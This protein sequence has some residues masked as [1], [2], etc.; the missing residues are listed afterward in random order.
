MLS[1]FALLVFL[2]FLP[3]FLPSQTALADSISGIRSR[4]LRSSIL[5]W[6][7]EQA[8]NYGS[9]RTRAYV[10]AR[11][12]FDLH[13]HSSTL[14]SCFLHSWTSRRVSRSR[15]FFAWGNILPFYALLFDVLENTCAA[16]SS[17]DSQPSFH[18]LPLWHP[19]LRW[20]N[21][22]VLDHHSCCWPGCVSGIL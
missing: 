14:F 8:A 21:G 15:S 17:P 13:F 7:D 2:I 4:T 16:L 20:W 6:S 11:L 5:L 19:F 1:F 10:K 9:G 12:T 18:S 22:S 3:L